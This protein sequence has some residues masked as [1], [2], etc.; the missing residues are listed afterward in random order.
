[1]AK[2]VYCGT[3]SSEIEAIREILIERVRQAGMNPTM[4]DGEDMVDETAL[5]ARLRS[6]L[7]SA[8]CYLGVMTY[9]RSS[10]MVADKSLTELEYEIAREL[11]KPAVLLSPEPGSALARSLRQSAMSKETAMR[12]MLRKSMNRMEQDLSLVYFDD[13]ADLSVQVAQILA[14][15]ATP[16]SDVTQRSMPRVSES[17]DMETL[18]EEIASRTAAKLQAAE[19]RQ[20]ATLAEQALKYQEALRLKP[21]ELVFGKPQ[22]GSQFQNDIFVIM[23]FAAEYDPV[24]RQVILPLIE[25]LKLRC[26]R[27]DEFASVRGSVIEEV[28]AALNGCRLVIADIT[29]SNLNVFYELGIAH[30][31][32]KSAI[33][34]TQSERPEDVPFDVRHLRYI[35][36]RSD[37][38]GQRQLAADLESAIRW[39]MTDLEEGWV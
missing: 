22:S 13:E 30:T 1:M 16:D 5:P 11:G 33:L 26:A 12:D 6:K 3:S 15:W 24:Y 25:R 7:A 10:D 35:Q 27:G 31:L 28:W 9:S 4:L 34:I 2:T 14:S 37:E 39:L 18:A 38:A 19:Q 36:Y 32:N 29:G 17:L 8:D 20:Q 23:P 21:G